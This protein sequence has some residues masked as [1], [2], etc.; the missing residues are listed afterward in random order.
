MIYVQIAIVILLG[1]LLETVS[2]RGLRNDNKRKIY[3]VIC[4]LI[5]WIIA[6]LRNVDWVTS[7]QLDAGGY[8][9]SFRTNRALTWSGIYHSI[10]DRY[11]YRIDRENDIGFV[12][13]CKLIGIFTDDYNVFCLFAD[14]LFFVPFGIL[15]YRNTTRVRHIMLAMLFYI[16]LIQVNM[17]SGGRQMFALGLDIFA[18][19]YAMKNKKLLSLLFALLGV[20][21]HFSSLIALAPILMVFLDIKPKFTKWIHALSFLLFPLGLLFPNQIIRFMG[22]AAG[23]EKYSNYGAHA[24]AGGATAFILLLEV[25]SVFCF[26]AF[27]RAYLKENKNI[28]ELYYMVPLFTIFG[29][30]IH[31]NGTMIRISLYFHLYLAVLIPMGLDCLFTKNSRKLPNIIVT[32]ALAFLVLKGGVM[33]Y[34]FMWQAF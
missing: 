1:F 28:R 19:M 27:N 18:F 11:I 13:L 30:L 34:H 7:L 23:M 29:P 15:L 5:C 9:Y 3:L 12:V 24:I 32:A 10:L 2:F 26:I 33:D 4:L 6:A 21:I 8:R 20:T 14:L 31:S 17:I 25:M 16:S 22:N